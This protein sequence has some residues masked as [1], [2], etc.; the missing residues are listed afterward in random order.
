MSW[1][2]SRKNS[3]AD[4]L[5]EE[6]ESHLQE[7]ADALEAQGMSRPEALLAARRSFGNQALLQDRGAEVWEN[8]L[9]RALLMDLKSALVQLRRAPYIV[10]AAILILGLGIGANTAIFTV[11]Y[12][13]IYRKLPVERP[14]RLVF[15]TLQSH[16]ESH[17]EVRFSYPLLKALAAQRT[18]LEDVSGWLPDRVMAEDANRQ[19]RSLNVALVTGNAFEMLGVK[20][21]AGRLLSTEDDGL[22]R[23][24]RWPVVLS[25]SFW[26]E[27]YHRDLSILGETTE[28][29]NR[30]VVI[31]GVTPARFEGITPNVE[32]KM[33]L[34]LAFF[35]AQKEAGV[36]NRL[37][38]GDFFSLEALARLR[39]GVTLDAANEHLDQW[40]E[41]LVRPALAPYLAVTPS[42]SGLSFHLVDASRGVR[43]L[44][45]YERTLTLLQLLMAGALVFCCV[46]VTGLQ[47]ARTLERTHE[48]A[49]RVALGAQ[50]SHLIRQCFAEAL[51]IAMGGALLAL[52]ITFAGSRLLSSFLTRPGATEVVVVH[53]DW[54]A[55]A[56]AGAFA[57]V[58]TLVVGSLPGVFAKGAKPNAVLKAKSSMRRQP[59]LASKLIL[60]AHMAFTVLLLT[61]ASYYARNLHAL[62]S[63]DLG[64]NPEH[65]TEV[66]AQFQQLNKTSEEI[67][68]LYRRTSHALNAHTGVKSSTIT[69][70]T[71][72][73]GFDPRAEAVD[74]AGGT[75]QSVSFN[76]V[77]P[78]YFETLQ[79]PLL[80]G[81]EFTDE[82]RDE[83]HCIVNELAAA[84]LF[85]DAQPIGRVLNVHLEDDTRA[86]CKVV[87]VAA[88]AKYADI[89]APKSAILY[90]PITALVVESGTT[91]H[92]G[93]TSF[94]GNM[95]FLI[96]GRNDAEAAAAY[97]DVLSKISP[98]TGYVRFLPMKRQMQ[99]ALGSER[100]LF[101]M[102]VFFACVALVLSGAATLSLLLMR[103]NQSIPEIAIRVALG[104]TPV[105]AA[106][107]IFR[108]M[109]LL[110]VMGAAIGGCS[111]RGVE[112]LTSHYL[113][114]AHPIAF[115]DV[116]GA[117]CLV[118]TVSLCAGG[119]PALR[120]ARLQPMQVLCRDS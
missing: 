120:A 77:G 118:V 47:L 95:V 91:R 86:T 36:E 6:M 9:T 38:T 20:P 98:G 102:T 59:A 22:Q 108:E 27:K 88:S 79:T 63:Q 67:M 103:V 68:D 114:L 112:F 69:R 42:L 1:F 84:A 83:T 101:G 8:R 58:C 55:F 46:N 39:D 60:T 74:A 54:G 119:I 107:M 57:L 100:L 12:Q 99:D 43:A 32:P 94:R 25:D 113:H 28:I 71:Q 35:D 109:A 30:K 105:Q 93:H 26:N 78:R 85:R 89:H 50:R 49:V 40:T 117:V 52:P 4:D 115:I 110:I 37:H 23:P 53:P 81:R 13:A 76:M 82:D 80:A 2:R 24:A 17:V 73:T 90:L 15:V 41:P 61:S 44:M 31:I 7:E 33:F 116:F 65:V 87:G 97:R 92:V 75:M 18:D 104:A 70:I 51:L 16:G 14:D 72:L 64:Y 5:R 29:D 11:L 34:P 19:R 106:A 45:G 48:F 21:A 10:C 62:Y 66:V 3:I 56:V 111:L 96:R